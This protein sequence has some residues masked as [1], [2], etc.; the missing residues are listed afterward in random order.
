MK[1]FQERQLS[2]GFFQHVNQP[3]P[4]SI[5]GQV[6]ILWQVQER[7]THTISPEQI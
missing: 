1:N 3:E 2:Q 7:G 5:T 6:N 4:Q